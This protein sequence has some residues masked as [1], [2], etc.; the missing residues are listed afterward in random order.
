[1]TMLVNLN[2]PTSVFTNYTL[3]LIDF[4]VAI[5]GNI[6]SSTIG[7]IVLMTSIDVFWLSDLVVLNSPM[8]W[9]N[10]RFNFYNHSGPVKNINI[11]YIVN[12]YTGSP[13]RAVFRGAALYWY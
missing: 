8:E 11:R 7:E 5:E 10:I 2:P 9:Q 6:N 12:D 3:E 4:G 1:M 13:V